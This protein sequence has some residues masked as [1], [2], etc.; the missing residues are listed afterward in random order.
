MVFLAGDGSLS[1]TE[2]QYLEW[3]AYK[4]AGEMNS[5]NLSE[6]TTIITS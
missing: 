5:F 6:N 1:K 2:V 3:L 4:K